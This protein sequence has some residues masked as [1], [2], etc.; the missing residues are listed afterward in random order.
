ME[1]RERERESL[2]QLIE[3]QALGGQEITAREDCGRAAGSGIGSEETVE[4]HD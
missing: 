4:E 1:Q 3:S 2:K